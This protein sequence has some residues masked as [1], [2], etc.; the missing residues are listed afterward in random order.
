MHFLT[1]VY[2]TRIILFALLEQPR[3][4]PLTPI[5]ENNPLLINSIKRLLIGSVFAEFIISNNIP[6]ITVPLITTPLSL[7]LT[8]LTVTTLGFVLALEIN[9]NTQNLKY[10]YPSNSVKFSS[11]L[12][13]FPTIKHR[14]PP[15]LNLLISQQSAS[16][17]LELI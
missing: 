16:S 1:A 14:L 7:K 10:I 17:L 12:G 2:S 15:D 9:L 4:C 6:P 5:N 13:Y 11:L 8:A 3:F